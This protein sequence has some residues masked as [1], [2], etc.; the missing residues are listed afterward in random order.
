MG[1]KP[2]KSRTKKI[3]SYK[4]NMSFTFAVID[5]QI[6]D[7]FIKIFLY[8]LGLM[9]FMHVYIVFVRMTMELIL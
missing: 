6:N 2:I 1:P 4:D 7:Y 9:I 8:I 5:T 3:Q